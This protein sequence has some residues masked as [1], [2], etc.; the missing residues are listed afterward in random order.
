MKQLRC[1]FYVRVS[2][3]NGQQNPEVQ[4]NDMRPFAE[5]RAWSL[6]GEYVDHCTGSKESRPELNRLL[7][8]ARQ[9]K[10]DVIVVWKLDRFARSLKH[11]VV[12]LAEFESLGVQFVSLKDNLD[13]TTASGRLMFQIIGAMA[14]FERSLI[15]ERVRAGLR[16]ARAKGVRLGRPEVGAATASR[17]TLW[18]RRKR[19]ALATK[20][21]GDG[22]PAQN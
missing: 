15:Q 20:S 13:L 16:N 21:A 19:A 8:D 22:I 4:L 11:L 1:A 14:E 17:Q 7:A 9:R 18:R 2:T 10:F 12:A 3:N 6:V 5:S